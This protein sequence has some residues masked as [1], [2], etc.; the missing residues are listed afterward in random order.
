MR[1]R[2]R[3]A[4]D[5]RIR[6]AIT[7]HAP[8]RCTD[9]QLVVRRPAFLNPKCTVSPGLHV[10]EGLRVRLGKAHRHRAATSASR[11]AP[12]EIVMRPAS[13]LS[14]LPCARQ[15]AARPQR[16]RRRRDAGAP[17][18]RARSA[19]APPSRPGTGRSRPPGR[20]RSALATTSTSSPKSAPSVTSRGSN[21]PLPLRTMATARLPV[22]ITASDGTTRRAL[23]R[24]G[25][26]Q[27]QQHPRRQPA[28]AVVD[29]EAGLAASASWR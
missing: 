8:S 9:D 2:K 22:R 28:A 10:G 21:P 1:T 13:T 3:L 29:L 7:S 4:T 11:S 20:P 25:D 18:C 23:V 26:V 12:C 15:V 6:A 17:C 24:P 16:G 14:T 27:A 19:G 5:Q